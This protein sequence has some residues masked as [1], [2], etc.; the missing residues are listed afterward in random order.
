[1]LLPKLKIGIPLADCSNLH[2]EIFNSAR[3]S[4]FGPS[5][6]STTAGNAGPNILASDFTGYTPLVY[7]PITDD[8]F[9]IQIY[10]GDDA[11]TITVSFAN[12]TNSIS[13]VRIVETFCSGFDPLFEFNNAT[14]TNGPSS[15]IF[16]FLEELRAVAF[17]FI[18]IDTA[19]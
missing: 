14:N 12:S 18:D 11:V 16:T 3:V 8:T 7:S 15:A 1:M 2:Y 10:K 5:L 19:V 17:D 4:V 6:F 9:Y 13:N